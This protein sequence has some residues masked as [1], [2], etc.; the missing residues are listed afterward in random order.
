VVLELAGAAL[1]TVAGTRWG[2]TDIPTTQFIRPLP[3]WLSVL[4]L[5]G[6]ALGTV[7]ANVINIYSGSMSFLVLGIKLPSQIRRA[8]VALAAGVVGYVLGVIL[9]SSGVV[10]KYENFL[11]LISYW[12]APFLGVVLVDYWLRRGSYDEKLFYDTRYRPWKGFVAMAVGIL[13]SVP[14]WNNAIFTGPVPK[15]TPGIGDVTFVVGFVVAAAVHLVLNLNLR[16][17]AAQAS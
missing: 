1:V 13:A 16:R 9:Q 8:I 15:G 14:F 6:I 12:I 4:A 17:S 3:E 2:P 5:L 11:L 7:S 10:S